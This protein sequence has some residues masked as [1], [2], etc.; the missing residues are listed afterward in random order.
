MNQNRLFA[1]LFVLCASIGFTSCN[2]DDSN[3]P[4]VI[5]GTFTASMDDEPYVATASAAV[6]TN[7]NLLTIVGARGVG[8]ENIAITIHFEGAGTYDNPNIIYSEGQNAL[9]YTNL[10]PV[11]GDMTGS[12]T[13]TSFANMMVSGTFNFTA[14]PTES[15][16]PI[17]FSGGSFSN[18][19]VTLNNMPTNNSIS[20]SINGVAT[21]FVGGGV[22]NQNLLGISGM[23]MNTMLGIGITMPAD[24]TVGT[25]AIGNTDTDV[26][27][28]LYGQNI[29]SVES[30]SGTLTV[31]AKTANSVKGTFSFTGEDWDGNTYQVTNG[32]FDVHY[33]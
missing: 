6:L 7:S 23:N 33:Q 19:P 8:G 14:Y 4:V 3:E 28:T 5:T 9:S 24:I 10:N 11:I 2:S 26:Y 22:Q 29:E 15:G 1:V 21:S 13:I 20:A 18:V 27:I 32:Q 16:A 25:H 30:V 17:E 12:V 31:T